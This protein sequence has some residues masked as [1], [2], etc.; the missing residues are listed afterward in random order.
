MKKLAL[1]AAFPLFI[2]CNS[3]GTSSTVTAQNSVA[4]AFTEDPASALNLEGNPIVSLIEDAENNS[5]ASMSLDKTNVS[6]VVE[7]MK[8]YSTSIVVVEDHTVVRI[9]DPN[10]CKPS[11]SW[12]S[13]MPL[14]E[15]YIRQ[16][17]TMKP[18]GDYLNNIIG[19][20]DDQK[21]T[22]YYFE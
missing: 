22:V 2:A 8:M 9:V 16:S 3:N 13:C 11:G 1:L 12:N 20:P 19:L 10:D 5:S 6:E 18:H 4:F 14:A 21:R 7:K 15:G 17:G